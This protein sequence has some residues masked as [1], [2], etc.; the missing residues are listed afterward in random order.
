MT[1]HT[2]RD[3]EGQNYFFPLTGIPEIR[4]QIKLVQ[5]Q[6]VFWSLSENQTISPRDFFSTYVGQ[7]VLFIFGQ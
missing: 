1:N 4:P 2:L 5:I 7:N 3:A 6:S